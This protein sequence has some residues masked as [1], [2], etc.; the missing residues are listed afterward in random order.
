MALVSPTPGLNTLTEIKF[1]VGLVAGFAWFTLVI[2]GKL[3]VVDFQRMLEVVIYGFSLHGLAMNFLTQ[4]AT[5]SK[6]SPAPQPEN[7]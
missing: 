5:L 4:G 3:P 1:V 6:Q 2:L 7:S